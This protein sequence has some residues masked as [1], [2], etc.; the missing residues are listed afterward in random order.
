MYII[1]FAIAFL[2]EQAAAYL[3]PF[4]GSLL[5]QGLIAGAVAVLYFVKKKWQQICKLLGFESA[6]DDL[7][8]LIEKKDSNKKEESENKNSNSAKD[9]DNETNDKKD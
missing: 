9:S 6:S 1:F 8:D 4:T 3:D 5:L 2:P 7:E